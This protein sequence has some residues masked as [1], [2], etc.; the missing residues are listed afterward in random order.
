M[1]LEDPGERRVVPTEMPSGS[2][3][4]GGGRK[5]RGGLG[6]RVG[7]TSTAQQAGLRGTPDPTSG[8]APL[9]GGI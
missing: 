1:R 5:R 9:A 8:R 6:A 7:V 4:A 2:D 3:F